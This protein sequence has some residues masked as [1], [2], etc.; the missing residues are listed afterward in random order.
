MFVGSNTPPFFVTNTASSHY[1]IPIRP[2]H[3]LT[4]SAAVVSPPCHTHAPQLVPS[5]CPRMLPVI[6]N[7][8]RLAYP[9]A[10][11]TSLATSLLWQST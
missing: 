9:V 2:R 7:I 6:D 11:P 4:P 1:H 10:L 5:G 3:L 8:A